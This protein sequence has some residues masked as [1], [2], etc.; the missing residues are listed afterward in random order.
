[1]C[2]GGGGKTAFSSSLESFQVINGEQ[3]GDNH[4]RASQNAVFFFFGMG[5]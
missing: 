2:C 3:R 1:M 5:D 4:S